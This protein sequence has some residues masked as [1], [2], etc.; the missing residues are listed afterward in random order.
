M[1]PPKSLRTAVVEIV[2]HHEFVALFQQDEAGMT[3][4]KAGTAG[5]EDAPAHV[6]IRFNL[7]ILNQLDCKSLPP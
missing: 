5:D 3:S 7:L 1:H 6:F 2:E 4:D